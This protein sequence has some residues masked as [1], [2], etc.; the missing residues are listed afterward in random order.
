MF[1]G[2]SSNKGG[3]FKLQILQGKWTASRKL[4]YNNSVATFSI[5]IISGDIETNPGP[6]NI[7]ASTV[8]RPIA[9]CLLNARSVR[10]KSADIFDYICEHNTDLCAIIKT[11]LICFQIISISFAQIV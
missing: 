9:L 5:L 1:Y 11:M 8:H 3:T 7:P 4:Y 6:E 10:N 2:L